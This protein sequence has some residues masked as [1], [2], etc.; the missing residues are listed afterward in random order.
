MAATATIAVAAPQC[1]DLYPFEPRSSSLANQFCFPQQI[2]MVSQM[3][4][5]DGLWGLL[6][7]NLVALFVIILI[8]IAVAIFGGLYWGAKAS[9]FILA[10]GLF[11]VILFLRPKRLGGKPR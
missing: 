8:A 7:R 5:M 4:A 1:Q 3:S 10:V 2:E 9:A 11:I 6:L